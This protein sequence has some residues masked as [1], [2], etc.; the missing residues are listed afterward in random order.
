MSRTPQD[1]Y[2]VYVL[3]RDGTHVTVF[4][5]EPPEALQN[6]LRIMRKARWA[7]VRRF[8][9]PGQRGYILRIRNQSE[10][11]MRPAIVDGFLARMVDKP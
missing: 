7:H 9:R 3:H 10:R 2:T 11:S 8:G 4:E 5:N 1:T 6:A